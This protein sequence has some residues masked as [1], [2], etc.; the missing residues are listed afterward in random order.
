MLQARHRVLAREASSLRLG[1]QFK[2]MS[3][4]ILEVD[5]SAATPIVEFAVVEAP[6]SAAERETSLLDPT[7]DRVELGVAHMKG[8]VVAIKA[9]VLV[10]QE[11]QG[12]IHVDG[13]K[14]VTWLFEIQAENARKKRAAAT[15]S[16]AGTM[17]WFKMIA[18]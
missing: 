11:S 1:H 15:L 7:E 18:I 8:V 17:V 14:V 9:G 3:I 2:H 5:A 10:E 13:R 4:Q 6:G 12:L 16:R